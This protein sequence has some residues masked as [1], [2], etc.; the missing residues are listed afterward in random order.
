MIVESF[1]RCSISF[2]MIISVYSEKGFLM[3]Y[4]SGKA[5]LGKE[6]DIPYFLTNAYDKL[7]TLFKLFAEKLVMGK[8]INY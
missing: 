2:S 1:M 3:S 7:L 8:S 4:E 5:I 6:S